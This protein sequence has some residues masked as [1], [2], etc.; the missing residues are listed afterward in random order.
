MATAQVERVVIAGLPVNVFTKSTPISDLTG[1][2]AVL[3][4]LHGREGAASDLVRHVNDLFRVLRENWA[5]LKGEK[6][7]VVA[8]F[9]SR[10][11]SSPFGLML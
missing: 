5:H 1:D 10:A 6:E 11:V 2:V 9:V 4:F 8:T 7:L 3:F